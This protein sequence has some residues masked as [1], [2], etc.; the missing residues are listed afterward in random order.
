M[1]EKLLNYVLTIRTDK[2]SIKNTFLFNNFYIMKTNKIL[3]AGLATTIILGLSITSSYAYSWN[4]GWYGKSDWQWIHQW[5]GQWKW[6]HEKWNKQEHNPSKMIESVEIQDVNAI[7]IDLLEKQYEGE[8]MA[9]ELYTSF[10]EKYWVETFKN[11]ADSEAK[12][13]EAIQV[14]LD[15]YGIET[16]TN[17]DHIQ[18]LYEHLKVKWEL[19][20]KDALEVWVSIEKVDID[21]IITAIKSTDND[22][23]KIILTNI[24]WAS[25]NHMRGFVKALNNNNL[26]TDIDYSDYLSE[27]DINTKWPIKVKLAEKL[28]SEWV[29][30]PEQA[31]SQYINEKCAKEQANKNKSEQVNKWKQWQNKSN[32]NSSEKNQYKVKYGTV[33]SKMSDDKLNTLIEKIDILSEKINDWNYSSTTK[34]KY[35]S[36]LSALRELAVENLDENEMNIDNLFQ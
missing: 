17:Y 24:G 14:L 34:Q 16:P 5:E 20:L 7:E 26:T 15:R 6:Q 36:I 10:Y 22:D 8:M 11:I 2:S 12:H 29:E 13:M 35:N 9:N 30:L 3:V 31:S 25:Y 27:D 28:E 4:G 33:I 19:S 32:Y 18:S 21:D 1:K 23:I